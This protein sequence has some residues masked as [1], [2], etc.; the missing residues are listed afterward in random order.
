MCSLD[1]GKIACNK[2][3]V[4]LLLLLLRRQDTVCRTSKQF[5]TSMLYAVDLALALHFSISSSPICF[6]Q[7]CG[8]RSIYIEQLIMIHTQHQLNKIVVF[9]FITDV[10]VTLATRYY[11]FFHR[12]IH[13]WSRLSADIVQANSVNMLKN[14]IH[15]NLTRADCI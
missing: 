12:T 14:R 4:L 13:W 1:F 3:P 15:N 8:R 2:Y 9:V 5:W 7:L 6:S 11:W 10:L